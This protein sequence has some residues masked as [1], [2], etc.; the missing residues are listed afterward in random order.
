MAYMNNYG[1]NL[2][3]R[4]SVIGN[5]DRG[6]SPPYNYSLWDPGLSQAEE[7]LGRYNFD[8]VG[9]IDHV[10]GQTQPQLQWQFHNFQPN[11]VEGS[12]TVWIRFLPMSF[13]CK[14]Q[15]L[16]SHLGFPIS[17]P[18]WPLL[19]DL[20]ISTP[21]LSHLGVYAPSVSNGTLKIKRS[22]SVQYE[23]SF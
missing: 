7:G 19:F 5:F 13:P 8:S 2:G 11:W 15:T 22:M 17:T 6:Q 23:Y 18:S 3:D 1:F 14:M 21:H 12:L 9:F 4:T 20:R 16:L 10:M